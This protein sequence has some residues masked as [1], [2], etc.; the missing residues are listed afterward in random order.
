MKNLENIGGNANNELVNKNINAQEIDSVT[1]EK[2]VYENTVSGKIKDI[3][4]RGKQIADEM[5]KSSEFELLTSTKDRGRGLGPA[6]P[7][8]RLLY[9][10]SLL[11]WWWCRC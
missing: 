4:E 3:R 7:A 8:R 5:L 6:A 1:P 10:R 9:R 11:F 2:E